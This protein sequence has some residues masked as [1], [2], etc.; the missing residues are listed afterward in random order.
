MSR[1]SLVVLAAVVAMTGCATSPTRQDLRSLVPELVGTV[2]ETVHRQDDDLLSAG[3]GLAGLRQLPAPASAVPDPAA[4]RRRAIHAS[5]RGIADL[6]PQS[7]P[8]ALPVVPGREFQAQLQ[9]AG[10]RHAH[11]VVLQLPDD[12]D[13]ARPCLVVAPASGS[14]GVY[15]AIAVAGPVA[16]PRGCAVVYTDK[17]AGSNFQALD[18]GGVRVPHAHSQDNPEARW[19]E[20]VLVAARFGLALLGEAGL[21]RAPFTAADTRV[22]AVGISNGGGAVLRATELDGDGL[23]AAAVAAAPNIDVDWPGSRPIY[24]YVTEAAIYQPCL[25][26]GEAWRDAPFVTDALREQGRIRCRL[27]AAAGLLDARTGT[28]QAREAHERLRA[29]GW[30]PG[31]LRLAGQNIAFDLWRAVAVTYASAYGRYG[32][33]EHPCGY[34]FATLDAGGGRRIASEAERAAW[35]SD[36]SGIPPTAGVA[37]VDPAAGGEDAALP[38]LMCLRRLWLEEGPDSERVRAGIASVRAS[39]R[40]LTA[41][42]TVLHGADDALVPPAFSSRPWVAAARARGAR[43]ASEELPAVQ[44]FDAFLLL[45]AMAGYQPLLPATWQALERTLRRD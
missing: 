30:E 39:G 43:I 28:G 10:D 34:G 15:G 33:G 22:V 37:L 23:L 31:A 8:E 12:F 19:G 29:A 44:H 6:R 4:L 36:G 41:N 5:W 21:R 18:D 14:R 17:G 45:P 13:S 25:L 3:L 7:M 40:P 26:A 9:L 42:I 38:G 24:D 32:T 35:S 2:T 1:A 20:H 11:R 27:L 16:L